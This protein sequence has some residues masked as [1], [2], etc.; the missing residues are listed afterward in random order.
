M[1]SIASRLGIASYLSVPVRGVGG[2][3]LGAITLV[4]G[5][6]RQQFDDRDLLT[7]VDIGRR[8]GQ[9]VG[10]SSMY[11]EQRHVAE[12]L[13]HSMLPRLPLAAEL[14]LAARY[15]PAAD[16]W[17]WAATGTTPSCSPTAT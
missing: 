4:N 5:S 1:A 12:V 14:E 2:T 15:Q 8:A 11:G 13:Q 3:V 9:A 16:R 10:N 7:A 17:R 6:Q